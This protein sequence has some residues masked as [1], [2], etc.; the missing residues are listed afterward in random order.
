[1]MQQQLQIGTKN[2][3]M[4]SFDVILSSITVMLLGRSSVQTHLSVLQIA[5]VTILA[6]LV[7][8]LLGVFEKR[9]VSN[10]STICSAF[11]RIVSDVIMGVTVFGILILLSDYSKFS[12]SETYKFVLFDFEYGVWV[13]TILLFISMITRILCLPE[14]EEEEEIECG[15]V[16]PESKTP[17]LSNAVNRE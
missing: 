17:L 12:S 2:L 3:M 5:V 7:S 4:I 6:L 8:I 13:G 11:Y 16:V 9:I 1:M 10:P 14:E 15:I